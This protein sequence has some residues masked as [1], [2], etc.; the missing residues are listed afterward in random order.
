MLRHLL[1]CLNPSRPEHRLVD[2]CHL[3]GL[4]QGP[5][6]GTAKYMARVRG[7]DACLNRVTMG[8]VMNIFCLLGMTNHRYNGVLSRYAARDTAVVTADLTELKSLMMG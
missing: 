5:T 6:E 8:E 3:V 4:T 7:F 1:D 2:I